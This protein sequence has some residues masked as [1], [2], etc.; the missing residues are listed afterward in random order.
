[1]REKSQAAASRALPAAGEPPGRR[2]AR[3][4]PPRPE[5]PALA[6]QQSARALDAD[7]QAGFGLHVVMTQFLFPL[8]FNSV[9]G[10]FCTI[11]LSF[12]QPLIISCQLGSPGWRGQLEDGKACKTLRGGLSLPVTRGLSYNLGGRLPQHPLSTHPAVT[13]HSKRKNRP[14]GR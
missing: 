11:L 3:A 8:G 9:L 14:N 4:R 1:M 6:P 12:R 7:E 5:P 2:C 10:I 13:G